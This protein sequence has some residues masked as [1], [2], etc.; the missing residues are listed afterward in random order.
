MSAESVTTQRP[1]SGGRAAA[2]HA[3]R[4]NSVHLGLPLVGTVEFPPAN[5]LFRPSS[6][7]VSGSAGVAEG[8]RARLVKQEQV[9]EQVEGLVGAQGG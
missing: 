9:A 4:R 7:T 1:S 3:T 2:E 6:R 8:C 5:E